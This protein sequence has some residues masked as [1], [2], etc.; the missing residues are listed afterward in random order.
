MVKSS[1][2]ADI[3][4]KLGITSAQIVGDISFS[5]HASGMS[6]TIK[7]SA[8]SAAEI[9]QID[10]TVY[11]GISFPLLTAG[12]EFLYMC[13]TVLLKGVYTPI[14]QSVTPSGSIVGDVVILTTTTTTQTTLAATIAPTP[15]NGLASVSYTFAA[16]VIAFCTLLTL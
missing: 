14:V 3:I 15:P 1:L 16:I 4:P 2:I 10:A 12:R 11:A 5:S 8:E 13:P 6:M 9:Q 7:I